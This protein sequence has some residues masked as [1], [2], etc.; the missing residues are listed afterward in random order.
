MKIVVPTV[1]VIVP[2]YKAE[3]YLSKCID[4]ILS[5]TYEGFEL[6]LIDDGSPD[7]CGKICD[8]YAK[9]DSRIKVIHKE[10]GGVSSARNAGIKESIGKY[11]CFVDSDDYIES[12]Y[13]ELLV[14]TKEENPDFSNIWCG[15]CTV[16]DYKRSIT[17][18]FIA[19]NS[20]QFS[21]YSVNNIMTL[22][23][24]WLDPMPWNKIFV[25]SI[26]VENK[27]KFPEDLTLGED[28]I[29]NF[30]YL[31]CTNKKI[32]VINKPLYDYIMNGKDS[33]D[34]KYYDDLLFI[35]ER[36]NKEMF[37]YAEKW[38]IPNEQY[39][40]LYNFSFY[41]F[42]NVLKNTFKFENRQSKKQKYQYNRSIMKSKEFKE[43]LNNMSCNL[44]FLYR[45]AYKT[46]SYRIVQIV[47]KI[48]S[49]HNI[50]M[51]KK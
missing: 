37:F 40:M 4:S 43:A 28:L 25:R 3:K 39:L 45:W 22:H 9:R 32:K 18:T 16:R 15:F 49:M 34:N 38:N 5:Q 7:G 41:R 20:E 13:L 1:S 29:F 23:E 27:I 44:H 10:N 50:V 51:T 30:E 2:V 26:I 8:N 46:C 17:G 11:I 12:D 19:S 33:L 31:D 14:R 48:I 35:Y 24:K 21:E 42:E 6:I 36:L 47:D